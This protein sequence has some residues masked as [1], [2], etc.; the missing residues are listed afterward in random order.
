MIQ[1]VSIKTAT[2]SKLKTCKFLF[3]HGFGGSVHDWDAV[4][5]ALP[6]D[7][8]C[9]SIGLPGHHG[10]PI[11]PDLSFEKH[12]DQLFESHLMNQSDPI[13]LVGYSMGARLALSFAL[14]HPEKVKALVLCSTS[15]GVEANAS[16]SQRIAWETCIVNDILTLE[17]KAFFEKWYE[18]P[19]FHTLQKKPQIMDEILSRKSSLDMETLAQ[20]FQTFAL[21][22]QPNYWDRL[23]NL[24]MPTLFLH[25][26]FDSKYA[27]I[28]H[29]MNAILPNADVKAIPNASHALHIENAS[30]VAQ[31][32][33]TFVAEL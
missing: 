28:M 11:N 2:V 6:S 24:A 31:S 8:K 25:G 29:K 13:V 22:H 20:S 5:D 3:L 1:Q 14:R 17:N 23:K 7:Y 33:E 9:E 4:I 27:T 15:A 16:I 18:L 30:F 26:E 12:V 32:I 10:V 21:S 19:L